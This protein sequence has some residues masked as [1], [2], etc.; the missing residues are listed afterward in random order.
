MKKIEDDHDYSYGSPRGRTHIATYY[1]EDAEYRVF[2]LDP[3]SDTRWRRYVVVD[4]SGYNIFS[5]VLLEQFE[6]V[7]PSF[8]LV[9][10]IHN[11]KELGYTDAHEL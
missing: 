6:T 7:W 8:A 3:L 1:V 4:H 9:H 2:G 11:M 5:G 10:D